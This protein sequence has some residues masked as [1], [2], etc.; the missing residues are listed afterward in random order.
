[1]RLSGGMS[2]SA[3]A[4]QLVPKVVP[5]VLVSAASKLKGD[6]AA[7]AAAGVQKVRLLVPAGN[8]RPR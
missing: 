2:R 1:M 3:S 6:A 5:G 8:A 4:P 7:P